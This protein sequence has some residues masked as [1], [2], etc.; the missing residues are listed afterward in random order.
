MDKD[1]PV[2][3][4]L[5]SRIRLAR[6]IAGVAFPSRQSEQDAQKIISMVRNCI[7][8]LSE[9]TSQH[10][11]FSM[12]EGI[13]DVERHVLKERHIISPEFARSGNG[14]ALLVREDGKTSVMINEEDHLRIQCVHEGLALES[15]YEEASFVDEMLEGRLNYAFRD[16]IGYL[17]SCPTNVGTGLRA[18]V[19]MHLPAIGMYDKMPKVI[20]ALSMAGLIVRGMYGEGSNVFGDIYQ[21]SNQITMGIDEA[22]TIEKLK[23]FIMQVA[24]QEE[25]LRKHLITDGLLDF[26][27]KAWRSYG[28]L[29]YAR[30]LGL[31]EA[32]QMISDVMLA[33]DIGI[34]ECTNRSILQEIVDGLG[35]ASIMKAVGDEIPHRERLIF[36]AKWVRDLLIHGEG[37]DEHVR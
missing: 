28:V 23:C 37:A 20:D 12:M 2:R 4:V 6:N 7:G 26:T 33:V 16:D 29:K 1:S 22:S 32:M 31:Q 15:A 13:P 19:M 24:S 18:S 25:L 34:I 10:W 17:T 11:D 5:S 35:T 30:C 3:T 21:I 14:R 27:D 9:K 36:R 8:E